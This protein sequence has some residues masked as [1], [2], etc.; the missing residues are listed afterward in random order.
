MFKV[1]VPKAFPLAAISLTLFLTGCANIPDL[2]DLVSFRSMSSF[3]TTESFSSQ[4]TEWPTDEWWLAYGDP[5]LDNLIQSSFEKSPDIAQAA[6]RVRQAEGLAQQQGSAL[7]PEVTGNGFIQKSK[8]S[9]Y[10]GAPADFVPHGFQNAARA[11]LDIGYQLDFWGKNRNLLDAAISG[12]K[13]AELQAAQAR[14]SL[15]ASI[16]E[17]YSQ[18]VQQY[19]AL[20][21]AQD[22]LDIRGKTADL[23][24]DRFDEGLENAGG[25]DQQLAAQASAE[26]E[27][28]YLNESIALTKNRL[29]A[30]SGTGPDRAL[31][32]G[33]PK[34]KALKS[35]GLPDNVPAELIGR[36]PDILAAKY[37]AMGAAKR[38][39]AAKADFY[40][41]INLAAYFGQQSLGLEYFTE[42]GSFIGAFGPAISL[43]IFEGGRLSGQYKQNAAQYETAVAQ[44]NATLITALNEVADAATSKKALIARTQKTEKAVKASERAYKVAMDRYKGGL[45]PYLDVLRAEDG[46]VSSRRELSQIKTRA[47]VLDVQMVRALGGGFNSQ[48]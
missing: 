7:F 35:F 3:E 14:L 10:N 48:E 30:L 9:Y 28:E 11:T 45:S 20:D 12:K 17:T 33:R 46:V 6:A 26:A 21:A 38:V 29:A 24:K 23:I 42:K 31:L 4:K 32:I 1:Q 19:A 39:D 15:A 18:L 34:V 47:F 16:A 44:Y 27:I 13:A 22:A 36:R 37:I 40:P 43:P 5:Q 25:Y 8:Q 2:D 41:N